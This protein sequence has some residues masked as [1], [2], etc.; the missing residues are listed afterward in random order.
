MH[1][2]LNNPYGLISAA[3][4]NYTVNQVDV[5]TQPKTQTPASR[6]ASRD[7]S[8]KKTNVVNLNDKMTPMAEQPKTP[9][10]LMNS[11][12]TSSKKPNVVNFSDRITAMSEPPNPQKQLGVKKTEITRMKKAMTL[13]SRVSPAPVNESRYQF[14][15]PTPMNFSRSQI[16]KAMTPDEEVEHDVPGLGFSWSLN[17][18]RRPKVKAVKKPTPGSILEKLGPLK[19][20]DPVGVVKFKK[21]ELTPSLYNIHRLSLVDKT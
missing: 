11:H 1:L 5:H 20:I 10:S 19:A 17:T 6:M 3:I 15:S 2:Y 7:A 13:D 14:F 12:D 21:E 16:P 4:P 8:N 18:D 9:G